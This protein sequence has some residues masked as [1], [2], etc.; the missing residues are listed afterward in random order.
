[1]RQKKTSV[2]GVIAVCMGVIG[3]LSNSA[4]IGSLIASGV[5]QNNPVFLGNRLVCVLTKLCLIITGVLIL[6][7]SSLALPTLL[8]TLLLSLLDSV[9]VWLW[10]LPPVP[11]GLSHAGRAGRVVGRMAGLWLPVLLYFAALTFLKRP[12][13][14]REFTRRDR[15][16]TLAAAQPAAALGRGN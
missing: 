11:D 8:L 13:T 3:L 6:R 15:S 4:Q 2:I 14:W 5:A 12:G 1:M 16:T 9:A 7:R 10:F